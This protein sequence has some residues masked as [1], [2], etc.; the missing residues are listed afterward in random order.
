MK[1]IIYQ[2]KNNINNKIYIGKHSTHN[3]DDDYMGS[4]TL[5]KRAVAKHGNE[6]F[7][8]TILHVFDDESLCFIKE[9]EIVTMEFVMR[10]DTYNLRSGGDGGFTV[11][12]ETRQKMREIANS[13]PQD[14]HDKIRQTRIERDN[15]GTTHV[16]HSE[17]TKKHL[18]DQA[19]YRHENNIGDTWNDETNSKRSD[20][21]R[22]K[23]NSLGS[24]RTE[25]W[26]S[27][28]SE[29]YTGEKNPNFGK[30][31]SDESKKSISESHKNGAVD[32]C[33]HCGKTGKVRNMKPYH[34]DNCKHRKD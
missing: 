12:D 4:G 8:K 14:H 27:E 20:S 22:G 5:I 1:H 18:S 3:I 24:K 25:E 29:Q 33:L 31:M 6:N 21:M 26:K 13:R 2:I 19:K 28:R 17:E 10:D 32:T 7:T 34:F 30:T 23:Q 11:S 16:S 15:Y 9:S